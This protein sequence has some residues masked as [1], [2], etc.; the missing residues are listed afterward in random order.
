MENVISRLFEC[1]FVSILIR[2]FIMG[3]SISDALV[4]ITLVGALVYKQVLNKAKISI[5]DQLK[6][7]MEVME[8][9]LN[10]RI[11]EIGNK[12]STINLKQGINRLSL[13]EK[14]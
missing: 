13:N 10:L 4:L 1:A 14:R 9:Q 8:S 3:P 2:S 6:K 12:V 11:D 7:Q 5:E